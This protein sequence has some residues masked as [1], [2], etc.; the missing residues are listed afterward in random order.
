MK[1]IFL[2]PVR[3]RI[4]NHNRIISLLNRAVRSGDHDIR[5]EL[6]QMAARELLI[7]A[8]QSKGHIRQLLSD[9]ADFYL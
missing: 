8:R 9:Q 2:P 6:S 3:S 4:R 1:K 7:A 5:R